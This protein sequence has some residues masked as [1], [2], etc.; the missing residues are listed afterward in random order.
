VA[1]ARRRNRG[2]QVVEVAIASFRTPE[3]VTESFMN[4]SRSVFRLSNAAGS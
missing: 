3:E 1:L 4:F 2:Q